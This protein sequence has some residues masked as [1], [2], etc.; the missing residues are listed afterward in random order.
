MFEKKNIL[1]LILYSSTVLYFSGCGS[2]KVPESRG[3]YYLDGIYF[4]K[5]FSDLFK[6]G[7]EDGCTTSKGDYTKSHTKFNDNVD[8]DYKDGWFLGRNRCKH[9]LVLDTSME[10]D[11]KKWRMY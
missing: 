3:G 5:N 10:G 2:E 8:Y 6:E 4:G 7:I 11:D 9:L 1:L